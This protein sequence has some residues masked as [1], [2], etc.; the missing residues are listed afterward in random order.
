MT[1][2]DYKIEV[3]PT[4]WAVSLETGCYSDWSIEYLFFSA[5][6]ENEVWNFLC[7]YYEDQHSGSE[8][9][10][11]ALVWNDKKYAVQKVKT[12]REINWETD[13]GDAQFVKI[14]RLKVI[15]FQK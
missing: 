7:R 4:F 5:N 15:H 11:R 8:W 13:Y 1:K 14:E 6:D 9:G 3:K 10:Q 2:K 12:Q